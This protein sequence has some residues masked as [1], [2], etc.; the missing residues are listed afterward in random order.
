MPLCSVNLVVIGVEEVKNFTYECEIG[1]FSYRTG[2]SR[3]VHVIPV[4]TRLLP[5][6]RVKNRTISVII[7]ENWGRRHSVSE[8]TLDSGGL[9]CKVLLVLVEV[10][11]GIEALNTPSVPK[12]CWFEVQSVLDK[13]LTS[14]AKTAAK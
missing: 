1:S 4:S 5:V 7:S 13:S 6:G 11:A 3:R 10:V 8:S 9:V 12:I 14:H 2:Y